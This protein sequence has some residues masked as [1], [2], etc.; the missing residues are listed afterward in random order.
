MIRIARG[1]GAFHAAR[2]GAGPSVLALVGP[3][4]LDDVVSAFKEYGLDA[5]QPGVATTGLI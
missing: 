1:A 2:S 3:E 4:S 5:I